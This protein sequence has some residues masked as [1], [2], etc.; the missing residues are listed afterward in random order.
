MRN[1]VSIITTY[2]K[3]KIEYTEK[4]NRL[5]Y[6]IHLS[7]LQKQLKARQCTLLHLGT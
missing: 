5:N 6:Q 2:F 3:D 1:L 4:K 7:L